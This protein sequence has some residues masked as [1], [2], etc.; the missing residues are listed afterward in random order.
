MGSDDVATIVVVAIISLGDDFVVVGSTEV[1]DW[2]VVWA[3]EIM[4]ATII[5]GV[6]VIRVVGF[7]L[8]ELIVLVLV[9]MKIS[10]FVYWL[11]DMIFGLLI[12]VFMM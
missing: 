3:V 2:F 10:W 1:V 12:I 11:M 6:F 8:I 4:M 9:A 7:V 5:V